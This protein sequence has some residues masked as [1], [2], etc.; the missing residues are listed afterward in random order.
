MSKT[1]EFMQLQRDL[2][3]YKD[4]FGNA[5]EQMLNKEVTKYPIFVVHQQDVELGV[6]IISKEKVNGNWSVNAT[7]LEELVAKQV[8]FQEKVEDFKE[9]YKDPEDFICLFILSEIGAQFVWMPRK[10]SS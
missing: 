2:R 4:A 10:T 8:I 6:E 9:V 3:P 5:I 7:T 1:E